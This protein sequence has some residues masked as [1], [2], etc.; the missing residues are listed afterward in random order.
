MNKA[1][2]ILGLLIVAAA[3]LLFINYFATPA[4][5]PTSEE[6]RG[7]PVATIQTYTSSE[8]GIAFEYPDTYRLEERTSETFESKPILVV[9]LVDKLTEIPDMSEG[10]TAVSLIVASS[11][12]GM[13]LEEWVKV[14]SIS[15]FVLS[16]DG[17]FATTTFAGE[18][19][20]LY[21]FSGLYENDAVAVEHAGKIY[22]FSVS[23]IAADE[24]IRQDFERVLESARFI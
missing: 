17:L 11:S 10:P 7:E 22:L 13:T 23:W 12:P 15:N 14:K 16:P 20:M 5:L 18:E 2:S 8:F 24:P 1:L 9:T 19:A 4:S 21:R 6:E 3:A